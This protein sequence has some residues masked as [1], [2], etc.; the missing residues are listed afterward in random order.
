MNKKPPALAIRSLLAIVLTTA[1]IVGTI[2]G[3]GDGTVSRSDHASPYQAP[4][5]PIV[6][7]QGRCFNGRCF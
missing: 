1:A 3:R 6:L 7:A 2:R 4:S 5:A